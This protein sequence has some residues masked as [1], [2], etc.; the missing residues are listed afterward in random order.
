MRPTL[1]V[2][3]SILRSQSVALVAPLKGYGVVIPQWE[4]EVSPAGPKAALNG[5]IEHVH[6]ELVKLN[7][8]WDATYLNDSLSTLQRRNVFGSSPGYFC[9]RRWG[10]ALASEIRIGIRYLRG[11]HGRPTN[12]PGWG[13]CSRVSCSWNSAIWWCNDNKEAKTLGS[14]GDIADGA[15]WVLDHCSKRQYEASNNIVTSGQVFHKDNWN[16]IVTKDT[17]AC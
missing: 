6:E 7:P 12:G 5:T 9:R 14:F 16:V 1:L 10:D 8:D 2:I 3:V 15:Q 11:V 13:T 17:K 4:V